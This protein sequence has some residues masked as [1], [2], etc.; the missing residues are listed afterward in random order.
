MAT[1]VGKASLVALRQHMSVLRDRDLLSCLCS[2]TAMSVGDFDI[3]SFLSSTS[4]VEWRT[5]DL[6]T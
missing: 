4:G 1:Q 6:D 5:L 2:V 3:R